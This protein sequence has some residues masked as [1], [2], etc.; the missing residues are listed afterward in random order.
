MTTPTETPTQTQTPPANAGQPTGTATG[1]GRQSN[2]RKNKMRNH[3]AGGHNAV[4]LFKGASSDMEGHVFLTYG[5]SQDRS[6]FSKTLEQLGT[7]I[8]VQMKFAADLVPIYK[9]LDDPTVARPMRGEADEDDD[10][11]QDFEDALFRELIKDYVNRVRALEDNK[12]KI[13][14]LAWGQCSES[15]RSKVKS[16]DDFEERDRECN[17][18]WLLRSIRAI[19]YKFEGQRDICLELLDAYSALEYCRQQPREATTAYHDIFKTIVDAYEHYGGRIGTEPGILEDIE[20]VNDF[21]HPGDMPVD[22]PDDPTTSLQMV[23]GF[24]DAKKTYDSKI[25]KIA[26]DRCLAMMFLKKA[27]KA[28]YGPLWIDLQNQFSRQNNQYPEDLSAAFAMLSTYKATDT[29]PKVKLG[30]HKLQ[31]EQQQQATGLQFV[32]NGELVPDNQGRTF[33]GVDCYRCKQPGHYASSCPNA[34]VPTADAV[35]LLQVGHMDDDADEVGMIFTQIGSTFSQANA[36]AHLIPDSWVLLDSQSTVSVFKTARYLKNIR[37]SASRLKVYTNGGTQMSTMIGDLQNFGEVWYNPKSLANILSLAHVRKTCRVTMDTAIEN[38]LIIHR[39]DGTEMKFREYKTGLYYFDASANKSKAPITDY[40]FVQTVS[41]LKKLFSRRE[42]EGA[43]RARDLL[44]KLGR[45]S[46][47][48]FEHMLANNVIINCPVTADDARRALL[49]YGP[50]VPSLKGKMTRKTGEHVPTFKPISIPDFIRKQHRHVTIC[51]DYFFIQGQTFFHSISRK[52][53]FRTIE[54]IDSK[55]PSKTDSLRCTTSVIKLYQKRDFEV[56]DVHADKEFECIRTDIDPI[57]MNIVPHDDHVPEVERSIRTI[58]ERARATIHGLP[59]PK[60]TRLMIRKLASTVIQ[61]LNQM[62]AQHGVSDKLSPLSLVTGKGPLDFS[63]LKLTFGSYVQTHD[64]PSPTNTTRAR[65]LGAIA[66]SMTPD[67]GGYYSFMNLNTGKEISRKQFTV[68]PIPQ[69]VVDR[70]NELATSQKQPDIV[71]GCPAFGWNANEEAFFD[72]DDDDDGNEDDDGDN[73]DDRQVAP[74]LADTGLAEFHGGNEDVVDNVDNRPADND[75]I[76]DVDD[77]PADDAN[78]I[79]D[80]FENEIVEDDGDENVIITD[81]EILEEPESEDAEEEENLSMSSDQRSDED[82]TTIDAID[83]A[84][85]RSDAEH[86]DSETANNGEDATDVVDDAAKRSAGDAQLDDIHSSGYNLRSSRARTYDHKLLHIMDGNEKTYDAAFLQSCADLSYN[87]ETGKTKHGDT[88]YGIQ[89]LQHAAENV[90]EMP[91][92]MFDYVCNFMFNQMTADKGIK[93]HGQVA[94]DALFKEFAQLHDLEV[95]TPLKPTGLTGKQKKDALPSINLIKEKRCGKIKGRSVAD[96]RKQHN[97]YSKDEITSPTVSTDALLMTLVIDAM[98]GREVATADVPGAYLQA[99][100]DD[101]VIL[102]MTGASVDVLCQVNESYKEFV[103]EENG[104]KV[105]YLK[106]NR[107]L[108][109]CIKSAMLWYNLFS[110]TLEKMGFVIN[111]YD[112]C[113]ANKTINGKQCTIVWYVDDLKI[114]HMELSVIRE[115]LDVIQSKFSGELVVTTGKEHTYL[116]IDIKFTEEGTIQTRMKEY[117]MEGIAVFESFG[118]DVSGGA[119]TPAQRDLFI[120]DETS[121]RLD[122]ARSDA[123]HH[124]VAKDLYVSKRC[125]LDIQLAISFLCTRVS[126]STEQDWK[127]LRRLLQYLYR[128]RDEFLTLGGTDMMLIG[129]NTFIDVALAVHLDMKSHTGG[130]VTLGRGAVMSKSSKQKLNTTSSTTSELVGYSDYT[131]SSIWGN[132]FLD[133]QGYELENNT[134]QDNQ[135]AIK[136]EKNGRR[137]CGQKTRHIDIRYFYLK[138]L[139]DRG[140]I[141]VHYCPT[142]LMIADFFTKPLQGALFNRLKAAVMG[143]ISIKEFMET[144]YGTKECVER[145]NDGAPDVRP[146]ILWSD[147][148]RGRNVKRTDG[149]ERTNEMTDVDRK[150]LQEPVIIDKKRMAQ[151]DTYVLGQK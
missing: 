151:G 29:T 14:G 44:A 142:E 32:Q 134:H 107:A 10:A 148:V 19:M 132:K 98:E 105:I 126:K 39:Q 55:K 114:S 149:S 150:R 81:D 92:D 45:P 15:M 50:D 72:D 43:D 102:R 136:L 73:D 106:L 113:V 123:F 59:Y 31:Q 101:D 7:V 125:R 30:K 63:K 42:I 16:L 95:F 99:E 13:Y 133:W 83:N 76:D 60:F 91:K 78:E 146:K 66:L 67:S 12:R 46:Q 108:Y 61:T 3:R 25:R 85:Q 20:D 62:P 80:D 1:Q 70:V 145:K 28:R 135:S 147:M 8:N 51:A 144:P 87:L 118:E 122:D 97:M 6:R 38:C 64:D 74:N 115:I 131:P 120:V 127:K 56:M 58:K 18:V 128:T 82:D 27:D 86:Q 84:A 137:S 47:K 143:T 40:C 140:E 52:L 138:D 90:E 119:S 36:G 23:R 34:E 124:I 96:G 121:E 35:Q 111:P 100:M 26:R 53:Q 112:S 109:G 116:G 57:E 77:H 2:S 75:V 48:H 141:K 69:T 65:S 103:T 79:V 9:T 88:K 22:N 17:C 129:M 89:F 130:L 49:I 11:M 33:D 41:D 94:I 104:K 93:K 4:N 21:D 110:E 71:N 68:V 117:I 5:E 37:D 139:L 54:Y 24:L